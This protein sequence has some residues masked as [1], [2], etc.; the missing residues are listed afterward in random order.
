[1]LPFAKDSE[2]VGDMNPGISCKSFLD[3]VHVKVRKSTNFEAVLNCMNSD[4]LVSFAQTNDEI[5]AVTAFN[6]MQ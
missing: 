4:Y 3:V 2:D 5:R 1:M 6:A